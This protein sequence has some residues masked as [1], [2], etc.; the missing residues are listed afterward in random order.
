MN[1]MTKSEVTTKSRSTGVAARMT[2]KGGS[3]AV[4][5]VTRNTS[6]TLPFTLISNKNT[7][8]SRLRGPTTPQ[9]IQVEAGDGHEKKGKRFTRVR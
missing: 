2:T 5:D 1:A 3:S 9:F 7:I 8:V 6:L 4:E